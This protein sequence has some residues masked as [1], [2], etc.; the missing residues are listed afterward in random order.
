MPPVGLADVGVEQTVLKDVSDWIAPA[1]RRTR[2]SE[3][4]PEGL[5]GFGLAGLGLASR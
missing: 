3:P 1:A 5:T 2:S 4:Q